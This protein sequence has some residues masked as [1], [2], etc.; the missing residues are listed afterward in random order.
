MSN[1]NLLLVPDFEP[2]QIIVKN[3]FMLLNGQLQIYIICN[4]FE[5]TNDRLFS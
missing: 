3:Y 4:I 5:A 1:Q 2:I